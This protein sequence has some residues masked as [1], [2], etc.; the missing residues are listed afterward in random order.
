MALFDLVKEAIT[1]KPPNLKS[2]HFY[3]VDSDAKNQLEQ[4]KEISK[5][6]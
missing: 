5:T 6:A 2:P 4:L 3:K 1:N